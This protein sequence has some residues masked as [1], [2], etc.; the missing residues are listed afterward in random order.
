ME[1]FCFGGAGVVWSAPVGV[2]GSPV[3]NRFFPATVA[4]VRVMNRVCL[5]G[6]RCR[7]V[8]HLIR[9][10]R[11]NNR[12]LFRIPWDGV[13]FATSGPEK[14]WVQVN[15]VRNKAP[16]KPGRATELAGF[17]LDGPQL[18]RNWLLISRQRTLACF[19]VCTQLCEWMLKGRHLSPAPWRVTSSRGVLETKLCHHLI[20]IPTFFM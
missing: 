7:G 10:T 14:S 15:G 20:I 1:P 11:A 3:A 2:P 17:W 9:R 18:S 5:V 19:L 8:S 4:L 6:W 12:G 16:A 13:G